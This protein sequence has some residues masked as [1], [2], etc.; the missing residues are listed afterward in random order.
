MTA[1]RSPTF[2]SVVMIA[3]AVVGG[4][5]RLA[6]GALAHVPPRHLSPAQP[7]NPNTAPRT[8]TNVM[9]EDGAR[10]VFEPNRIEV[11]NGE[12]VRFVLDNN[13]LKNHEFVLATATENRKHA[14][15]M[16]THPGMEHEDPNARRVAPY[17]RDELLWRFT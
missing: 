6:V 2:S 8:V 4:G 17:N 16:R 11:R 1:R 7:G 12:Q 10:M 15:L 3:L 9:R 5:A 13:G 14:E